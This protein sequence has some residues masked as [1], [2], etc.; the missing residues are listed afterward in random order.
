MLLSCALGLQVDRSIR[1]RGDFH[2][3]PRPQA[4]ASRKHHTHIEGELYGRDDHQPL[5]SS[6]EDANAAEVEYVP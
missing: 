2:C 4:L 3:R 5:Q 1:A 6:R